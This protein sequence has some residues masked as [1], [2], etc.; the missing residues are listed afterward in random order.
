[1]SGGGRPRA[2]A[3]AQDG[4]LARW[5]A[6]HDDRWSFTLAYVGL[7]LLLST[8]ISLFWLVAVVVAHGVLEW[9]ALARR[10][11]RGQ[12]LEHVVWHLKLDIGLVLAALWLGLY[13]EVL[14]GVVGLGGAARGGAQATARFLAWQRALRGVVLS[15]D[16]AALLA[17]A[18][19]AR[20]GSRGGGGEPGT[21]PTGEGAGE[22]A[23]RIA[24]ADAAS[25]AAPVAVPVAAPDAAPPP[26]RRRWTRGDRLAVGFAAVMA[27]LI[28]ATPW[29]TDHTVTTALAAL[30]AELHPWPRG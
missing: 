17:R 15:A 2:R 8:V 5:I 9:F 24:A 4:P 23:T 6:E 13:V 20:S 26:W 1:M 19:I 10:G 18:A 25:D 30:A 7:A 11:V 16:D 21:L 12:R 22:R 3:D 14:F 29:L 27:L 28:A